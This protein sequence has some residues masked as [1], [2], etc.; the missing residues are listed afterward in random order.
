MHEDALIDDIVHSLAHLAPDAL[1]PVMDS[2]AGIASDLAQLAHDDAVA[3]I[4]AAVTAAA[5]VATT[6]ALDGHRADLEVAVRKALA[7]E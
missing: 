1:E 7:T 6:K 4:T 5:G 2:L 3:I